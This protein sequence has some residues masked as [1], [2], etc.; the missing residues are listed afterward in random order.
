MKIAFF[1]IKD[2]EADV[3]RGSPLA[4]GNEF[5]FFPG[6]I[7]PQSVPKDEPWDVLSVFIYSKVTADVL[8]RLKDLRLVATRSTGY[9]HVDLE[10]CKA[11]GVAVANVPFYGEN[12]V[13][14]H[15][16]ALILSLSRNVHKAYVKTVKGDFSLDGLEGFDLKGKTLGVVGAGHIGL[17]VVRMARGFGME[18]LAYDVRQDHFLE[19]V[20]GFRYASLD[21]LLS[22]SDIITLHAPYSEKTRH[23]I[24]RENIKK[25][26][27]GALLINTARGGLLDTRAL[28]EALDAGILSGAGLDTLEG[29][30]LIIEEK[31]IL[32]DHQSQEKLETL[33]RNHILLH[34]ENVVITPHIAFFSQEAMR[35][36]VETTV[37]NIRAF[38][39]GRP[40]NLVSAPP[41][42]RP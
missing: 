19:E 20:L 5:A 2:W 15:T 30:D 41:A 27:R 9:D 40:E 8:S 38:I 17:H 7:S 21:E 10:A 23:L 42:R 29:E 22:R 39:S 4:Q 1:E 24:N 13:A 18:V 28:V 35:R 37:S 3:I 6:P 33:V 31:Q 11:K 34:R 14:E 12:T 25:V 26:K 32:A 16:F 36:I